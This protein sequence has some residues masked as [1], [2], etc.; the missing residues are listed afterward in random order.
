[1][2]QIAFTAHGI[3]ILTEGCKKKSADDVVVMFPKQGDAPNVSFDLDDDALGRLQPFFRPSGGV[4]LA[5]G[6]LEGELFYRRDFQLRR[7]GGGPQGNGFGPRGA[8]RIALV[9]KSVREIQSCNAL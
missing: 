9:V 4:S 6:T 3:V 1:T 8:Y 2:G 5:C 7:F